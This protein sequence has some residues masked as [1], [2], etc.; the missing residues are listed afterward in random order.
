MAR[1]GLR[2]W[3]GRRHGGDLRR[4]AAGPIPSLAGDGVKIGTF[5]GNYSRRFYGLGPA[6]TRLDV[7]WK[8][9][10]GS[11]WTSGKYDTDPPAK[12]A[13]SGWTG[14]PNIVVDGGK[15][16]VLVGGYDH[17][18]RRLDAQTGAVVWEYK[19]DDIIKS[20]P[21]VFQN[22]DP[23]GAD[24]KYIVCAGSRRGYPLKIADPAAAPYR[25]VTFGSGKELWRLPVPQT[26]SYS[27]DCDGSGFF[28]DGR[29]YIGVESGWMYALDPLQTV[30]WNGQKRPVIAAQRLLLGDARAKSHQ[31]NL[32]LEASPAVL[33]SRIYV[34]SGA[35]HVY[36]LRRSDLAV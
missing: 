22:P 32:V 4:R 14:M 27:R 33:G 30:D 21:S 8:A 15:P 34:A 19:Y 35:G 2:L 28:L 12:W 1:R 5:L 29:Q 13:G 26:A 11:G 10:L 3:R 9:R 31:G 36:G 17:R 20:S 18:L 25:A 7:L 23:A 16:Y 6:P 24:D